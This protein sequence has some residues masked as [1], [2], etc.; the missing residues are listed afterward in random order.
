M[1]QHHA[2]LVVTHIISGDIWAGAEVQVY[3]LCKALT[4]SKQISVTAVVFNRGILFERLSTLGIPVTVADENQLGPLGISR[5]IAKHCKDHYTDI[6]HT[7]GF[8]EN[9]LGI[10]AKELARVP[11]SIR[12]VHGNPETAFSIARIHRWLISRIDVWLGR[13]RQH[14]VIAVSSQ[15]E[16]TLKSSFPGKV[17]KIFNFVDVKDIRRKVTPKSANDIPRLGIVGRMVPVK[18]MDLFIRT[19]ALLNHRGV[20]CQGVIIGGGPLE[21]ELKQ[22]ASDLQISELIEFRGFVDPAIMEINQLDGLVMTS[23]HEGLPMTLL[24]ALA[25]EVP[26]VAHSVGG[27]PEVLDQGACG[28]LVSNHSHEGYADVLQKMLSESQQH[29]SKTLEGLSHVRRVFGTESNTAQYLEVYH[30]LCGTS[31]R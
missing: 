17:R 6:V 9:V 25:L 16:D 18:R 26:I 3:N 8:K 15:L 2:T 4:E 19:I 7:H 27:I 5:L 20:S 28:W 10:I 31:F 24:E 12:T 22:L 30:M 11:L 1:M 29:P 21:S 23:E 13:L 14:A